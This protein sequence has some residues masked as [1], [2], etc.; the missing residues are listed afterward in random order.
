M[1]MIQVGMIL[2][3]LVENIFFFESGSFFLE[4]Y[5]PGLLCGVVPC[6]Q[7]DVDLLALKES[8]IKCSYGQFMYILTA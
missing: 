6:C 5:S 7:L 4:V 8:M 2:K 3:I 1:I